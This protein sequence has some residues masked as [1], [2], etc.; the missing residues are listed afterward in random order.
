MKRRFQG[1]VALYGDEIEFRSA[2]MMTAT[3]DAEE[4]EYE[5]GEIVDPGVYVDID[6]GA[7]VRVKAADELPVGSKVVQY[8]RRFRRVASRRRDEDGQRT[9]QSDSR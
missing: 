4:R 7:I 2:R 1:A 9:S 5:S 8:R 3:R 6:S